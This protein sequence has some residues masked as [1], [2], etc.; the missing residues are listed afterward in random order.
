MDTMRLNADVF[1]GGRYAIT[2][3]LITCIIF[4]QYRSRQQNII[5]P[6]HVCLRLREQYDMIVD[7]HT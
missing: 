4:R 3:A 7:F 6:I 1:F 5:L 2:F